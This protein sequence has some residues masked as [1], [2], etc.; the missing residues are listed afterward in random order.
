MAAIIAILEILVAL[1]KLIEFFKYVW[2]IIS[3]VKDPVVKAALRKGARLAVTRNIRAAEPPA[4]IAIGYHRAHKLHHPNCLQEL[5]AVHL[6]AWDQL[7][8]ESA[9]LATDV[10]EALLEGVPPPAAEA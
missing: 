2:G 8:K 10:R 3:R 1:P 5:Q 7:K 9:A 4:N 6:A